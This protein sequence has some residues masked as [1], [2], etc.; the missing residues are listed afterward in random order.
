MKKH[1]IV[2]G[3]IFIFLIVGLNGC[4]EDNNKPDNSGDFIRYLAE[5]KDIFGWIFSAV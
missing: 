2:I 3:I 4:I 1:L 5:K